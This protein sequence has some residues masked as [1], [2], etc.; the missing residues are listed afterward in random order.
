M[1][2]RNYSTDVVQWDDG[3]DPWDFKE[4]WETMEKGPRLLLRL[5][6]LTWGV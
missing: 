6:E 1:V 3:G 2:E 4:G 5:G